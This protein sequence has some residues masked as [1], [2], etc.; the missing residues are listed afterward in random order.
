MSSWTSSES[1]VI[2]GR[3]EYF[4][5]CNRQLTVQTAKT[6]K[7]PGKRFVTC[8][9]CNVYD[10][11]DDVL[12]SEYY[13]ELLYGMF[14]NQKQSKKHMDYEQ[15]INV[16]A[17]EKSMYEEELGA[18]KSKL[19]LYNRLFFI[20]LGSFSVV[21]VGFGM[22]IVW[23]LQMQ[24]NCQYIGCCNCK[25]MG[26][27]G[28]CKCLL[29][30]AIACLQMQDAIACLQMQ[31]AIASCNCLLANASCKCK[32]KL[33][34]QATNA[35]CNFL[36]A[37]ASCN[38]LLANASCKCKLQL[39]ACK[40]KLQLL[41]C[42][43]KMKI[44]KCK[45]QLLACKRKIQIQPANACLQHTNARCKCKLQMQAANCKMQMQAASY[46]L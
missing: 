3:V 21:C 20:M 11:L 34:L 30:A 12:P 42:K 1:R 14:Q 35:S 18:T 2:S 43:C 26:K 39:L 25:Q 22:L 40:C 31:T 10:F 37:N 24:A 41:A 16:L 5:K 44:C 46:N 17:M 38:C 13:K 6:K 32:C 29:Q 23:L 15:V 4:C 27:F 9:K 36:L 33:Q 7:N 19:K 8:S 45:L 28:Y